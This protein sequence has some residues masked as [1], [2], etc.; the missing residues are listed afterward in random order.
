MKSFNVMGLTSILKNQ[1]I[2]NR[3]VVSLLAN[4][5]RSV[6]SF[7]VLL[8][9]ARSLTS[10]VY[11]DLRF[12]IGSFVA[13]RALMDL[14]A[15]SAFFTFISQGENRPSHYFIYFSW[16]VIQFV[17]FGL[18]IAI[19]CPPSLLDVI[20]LGH[21]KYLVLLAFVASFLQQQGW[22]TIINIAESERKTVW[23]QIFGNVIAL[24]NLL[25]I[26]HLRYFEILT[27]ENI[28]TLYIVVYSV[29]FV[30]AF[31]VLGAD[32]YFFQHNIDFVR[33]RGIVP[34]YTAYCYPL[35][36]ITVISFVYAYLDTWILQYFG[37]SSQ[38]GLYQ[39]SNQFASIS[40]LAT[41]SVLT[42]FWKEIAT[43]YGQN[44]R[45]KVKIIFYK[46]MRGL[47]L[48][49]AVIS[50]FLVPW[51]NQIISLLLGESYGNAAPILAIML[52]YPI[53]QSIGQLAGTF[54]FATK[55][56][57][58]YSITSIIVMMISMP[59]AYLFLAPTNGYFVS[60]LGLGA[61]GLALKM[62]IV[63]IVGVNI[64]IYIISRLQRWKFDYKHQFYAIALTSSIGYI[65]Y[66]GA[67]LMPTGI[68]NF[69]LSIVLLFQGSIAAIIYLSSIVGI[70]YYIPEIA[71]LSRIEANNI[72]RRF[73]NAIKKG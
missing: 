19:I 52:F 5:G 43:A 22:Q 2:K 55:R 11:G 28:L 41:S 1:S 58:I 46:A 64:S 42:I 62:V 10:S 26:L 39:I 54:F 13:S 33:I 38:Q 60:G 7:V 51:T 67:Q 9:L 23:N 40:L 68:F 12:L 31:F 20:W 3:V 73:I 17:I 57:K 53:H 50:G 27:L 14:G 44:D 35:V 61:L 18:L 21:A 65:S 59:V 32:R 34:E 16:L 56:T 69:P 66:W 47:V 24:I 36:V 6:L 30:I 37:G 8:V 25:G 48:F 63:N 45:E 4:V 71:G 72:A 15:A 29:V 49:G 70:V